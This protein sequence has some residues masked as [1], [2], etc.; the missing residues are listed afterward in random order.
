MVFWRCSIGGVP[1]VRG[2][3]LL[4]ALLKRRSSSTPGPGRSQVRARRIA[5]ARA[6]IAFQVNAGS[7]GRGDSGSKASGA[8]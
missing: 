8:S 1:G 5:H 3:S 6:S 4:E 2:S 7:K